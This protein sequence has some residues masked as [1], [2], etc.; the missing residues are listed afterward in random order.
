MAKRTKILASS[1]TSVLPVQT[2]IAAIPQYRVT[3]LLDVWV[4]EKQND[5]ISGSKC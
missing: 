5:G 1:G 3:M 2:V 4:A